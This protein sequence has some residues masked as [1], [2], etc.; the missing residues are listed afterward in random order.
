M[1]LRPVNAIFSQPELRCIVV[2]QDGELWK[3]PR[4][5]QTISDPELAKILPTEDLPKNV[6]GAS[7]AKFKSW[8]LVNGYDWIK[9][10]HKGADKANKTANQNDVATDTTQAT[11]QE[12]NAPAKSAPAST[13]A[14]APQGQTASKPVANPTP[15]PTQPAPKPVAQQPVTQQPFFHCSEC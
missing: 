14:K 4:M 3:L 5:K 9:E 11:N 8:W 6:H 12:T 13:T 15:K 1:P 10:H 7:L 2:Y